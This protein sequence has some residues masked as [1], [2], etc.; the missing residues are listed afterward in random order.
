MRA[1]E[2]ILKSQTYVHEHTQEHEFW[3]LWIVSTNKQADIVIVI[4]LNWFPYSL[5][6][7]KIAPF[8]PI[9]IPHQLRRQS[10]LFNKYCHTLTQLGKTT[11]LKI[12]KLFYCLSKILVY[13]RS[14]QF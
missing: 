14:R 10:K 11:Q 8:G 2:Q 6:T 1:P 9:I 7:C 4:F 12:P 13:S 3:K 5:A